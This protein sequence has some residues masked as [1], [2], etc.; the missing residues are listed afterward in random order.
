MWSAAVFEP[1]L[2]R[3]IGQIRQQPRA[4]M[5]HDTG[6]VGGDLDTWAST[7]SVHRK[8]AFLFGDPEPSA[9]SESLTGKALS[10][11]YMR[12]IDVILKSRG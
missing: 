5:R 7:S 8:S 10:I 6:T 11:I 12:G 1:V 4:D 3:A 9:S 2:R